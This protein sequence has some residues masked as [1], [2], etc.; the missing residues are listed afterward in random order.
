ML[1]YTYYQHG[2]NSRC[3]VLSIFFMHII[4][5]FVARVAWNCVVGKRSK[6][7]DR[8]CTYNGSYYILARL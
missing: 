2:A 8:L 4:R 1:T 6:M 3:Q 5:G 7:R